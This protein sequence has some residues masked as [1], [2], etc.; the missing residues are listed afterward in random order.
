MK[1]FGV[2]NLLEDIKRSKDKN[3]V[4]LLLVVKI[5]ESNP[6]KDKCGIEVNKF[7]NVPKGNLEHTLPKEGLNLMLKL[8]VHEW[9]LIKK[10]S[11]EV[12]SLGKD[13]P[14]KSPTKQTKLMHHVVEDQPKGIRGFEEGQYNIIT[15]KR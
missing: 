13:D 1:P 2:K 10:K 8:N 3:V 5:N 4:G 14:Q 6:K 15:I 9:T 12:F 11:H 7:A